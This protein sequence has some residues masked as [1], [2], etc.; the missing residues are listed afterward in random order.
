MV[1]AVSFPGEGQSQSHWNTLKYSRRP[2][3]APVL[4]NAAICSS[5][6]SGVRR[7]GQYHIRDD[8]RDG[9]TG[10][11]GAS[12]KGPRRR[13]ERGRQQG[14]PG[15]GEETASDGRREEGGPG[16][17]PLRRPGSSKAFPPTSKRLKPSRRLFMSAWRT[18]PFTGRQDK[19]SAWPEQGWMRSEGP[20]NRP[21]GAGRNWRV[22]GKRF[23]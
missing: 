23:D 9:E 14:R 22:S 5:R 13:K 18:L 4:E 20:W 2:R 7:G 10:C 11:T 17:L 8:F 1:S 21:I 6:V 19:R 12:G 3:S 15:S 16:S